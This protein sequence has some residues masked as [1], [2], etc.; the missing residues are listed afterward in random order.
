MG[1]VFKAPSEE[2]GRWIEQLVELDGELPAGRAA[3]LASTLRRL[4]EAME[5]A[6]PSEIAQLARQCRELS[7]DLADLVTEEDPMSELDAI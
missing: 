3:V 1:I 6:T 4:T 5:L 2:V 7:G